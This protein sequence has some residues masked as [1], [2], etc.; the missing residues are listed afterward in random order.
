MEEN[1]NINKSLIQTSFLIYPP[2][3]PPH[4]HTPV[5]NKKYLPSTE[6]NSE[7]SYSSKYSW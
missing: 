2:P 6:N 1:I 5:C 7:R 4:T 3:P